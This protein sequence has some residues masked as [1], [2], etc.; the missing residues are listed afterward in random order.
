MPEKTGL[1]KF[2]KPKVTISNI[3]FKFSE[4][5]RS[6]N[7]RHQRQA[8]ENKKSDRMNVN[9]TVQT[10]IDK[11]TRGGSCYTLF[12]IPTRSPIT[13]SLPKYRRSSDYLP[14]VS[15]SSSTRT[16]DSLASILVSFSRAFTNSHRSVLFKAYFANRQ[17]LGK[18]PRRRP[19][20]M[21][22]HFIITPLP[23]KTPLYFIISFSYSSYSNLPSTF[24]RRLSFQLKIRMIQW[25]TLR[26]IRLVSKLQCPH[27]STFTKLI[28]G[29][30]FS[31][32]AA[33]ECGQIWTDRAY[34]ESRNSRWKNILKVL[35]EGGLYIQNSVG[36]KKG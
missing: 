2:E 16:C 23:H 17:T 5:C 29:L 7:R 25:K 9:L 1:L 36:M 33:I 30:N 3:Y 31:S 13:R 27:L 32:N 26:C 8:Q 28:P 14:N 20:A 11:Y 21:R 15:S 24:P 22:I 10:N 6:R 4:Q 34:L 35:K 12:G 18:Q 19:F